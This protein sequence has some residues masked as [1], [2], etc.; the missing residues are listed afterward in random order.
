LIRW[1]DADQLIR[2][3]MQ[4]KCLVRYIKETAHDLCPNR[5]Q[6]EDLEQEAWCYISVSRV[7][8]SIEEYKR[9]AR[10]AMRAAYRLEKGERTE[11]FE[12]YSERGSITWSNWNPEYQRLG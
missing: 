11:M 1:P 4:N 10:N 3:L 5:E 8:L 6:S 12:T 7:G 2:R 9:I